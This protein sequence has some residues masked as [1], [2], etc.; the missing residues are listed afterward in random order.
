MVKRILADRI[1][2]SIE[3]G[4]RRQEAL[5]EYSC[6][7]NCEGVFMRKMEI[8]N[9]T[10]R[11]EDR[12]WATMFLELNGTA[13]NVWHCKKDRAWRK[14]KG[15][16]K[17]SADNPPWMKKTVLA[18]SYSL[19]YADAGIAAD[20]QKRRYVIRIRAET[21]QF[22]ISCTELETFVKWLDALF[23]A[24]SVAAPLEDRDFPR[25]QSVP[26][27]QRMRWFRGQ[28]AAAL[29]NRSAGRR[30]ADRLTG[31]TDPTAAAAAA[32]DAASAT[33]GGPEDLPP[34]FIEDQQRRQQEQQA[35]EDAITPLP[36]LPSAQ[37]QR[38]P[39]PPTAAA[40]TAASILM[41]RLSM[42]GGGG[43]SSNN[44][45]ENVDTDTGKWTPPKKWTR[46]H[47]MVYAKL[48]YAVLLFTSPRKSNYIVA[49]GKQ[50]FV[51]WPTGRMVRVN[52][53]A[54]GETDVQGPW[55]VVRPE[56]PATAVAAAAAAAAAQ[57]QPQRA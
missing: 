4:E 35:E 39:Q 36:P 32:T 22:L 55:H 46:T 37:A 29:N 13:L 44:N 43:G 47:D 42:S 9:T 7:I 57:Q 49:R 6:D 34:Q 17:F 41:G 38:R 2:A 50:W 18:K 31:R 19:A 26:R 11:A 33:P 56:R 8:Q 48:C 24:I 30:L 16:P 12:H 5:P 15:A 53:P 1:R 40:Q 54:Y 21:D 52:P 25:D 23:A 20:Y 10:K 14:A 3:Q 27:S 51:D 45:N 28:A